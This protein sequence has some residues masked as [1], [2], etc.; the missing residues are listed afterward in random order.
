MPKK[1]PFRRMIEFT[2]SDSTRSI[3]ENLILLLKWDILEK[4]ARIAD[5]NESI[6]EYYSIIK[7]RKTINAKTIYR[8]LYREYAG[9]SR[10]LVP[11]IIRYY[12]AQ[13]QYSP[14]LLTDGAV[15]NRLTIIFK[16]LSND[17][18]A[19][20]FIGIEKYL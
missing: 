10:T 19:D 16:A 12:N 14:V 11:A 6:H 8:L 7:G 3:T 9:S 15:K 1:T 13:F 2:I 5:I 4:W 18:A 20:R 17:L